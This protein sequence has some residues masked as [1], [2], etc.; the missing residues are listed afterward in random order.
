MLGNTT[1]CEGKSQFQFTC[2]INGKVYGREF[3]GSKQKAKQLAA[4][5]A[6]EKFHSEDAAA[7]PE[8]PPEASIASISESSSLL[9]SRR[10]RFSFPLILLLNFRAPPEAAAAADSCPNTMERSP[11]EDF[12]DIELIGFGAYGQVFKARHKIDGKT[13]VIKRVKYDNEKVMREVKALEELRH[14]NI[15][16]YHGCWKGPDDCFMDYDPEHRADSQPETECLFIQMEFCG[17]G[18]LEEWIDRMR[19]QKPDTALA[20]QFFEQIVEGVNYIHEK[21][22]IHRDLKPSN[23]FLVDEKQIK[24]GD[25][26]FVTSLENDSQR[27][28]DTGTDWYRSPEQNSSTNYGS[29]VDIYALGIIFLELTHICKTSM[30]IEKIFSQLKEGEIPRG[31]CSREKALLEQLLAED[32]SKRPSAQELLYT[33]RSWKDGA[34]SIEHRTCC[35]LSDKATTNIPW[36]RNC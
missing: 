3:A 18:T 2:R 13:Y 24:I 25:F 35:S 36:S 31:F 17:Q 16:L 23:I 28:T 10:L 1:D 7:R 32:P 22:Y 6:L 8:V 15:V 11:V 34:G 26:G 4:Q 29:E 14:P 30:E 20:L 19:H 12:T 5:R 21:G 9:R 27:T 33:L